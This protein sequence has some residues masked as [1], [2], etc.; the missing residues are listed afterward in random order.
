MSQRINFGKHTPLVEQPDFLAIQLESFKEFL[1]VEYSSGK[2]SQTQLYKIFQEYFPVTDSKKNVLIEFIDYTLEEPRYTPG[3]AIEKNITYSVPLKIH[4]RLTRK[5]EEKP[6]IINQT[7]FLGNI[8]YMTPQASFVIKGIERVIVAQI[9]RSYNAFFTH[10]KHISGTKLHSAKIIPARGAWIEFITDINNTIYVYINQKKKLPVTLLLR[11]MGY[12]TDRDILQL[13]NL[14]E[15]VKATKTELHKHI[16]KKL[17][18]KILKTWTQEF[19]DEET[20]EIISVERSEVVL[21]RNTEIDEK[22]IQTI[23]DAQVKNIVLR[24]KEANNTFYQLIHNTFRKDETN[25]EK[26]AIEHIY[27]QI[28]SSEP[29]DEETAREL[30]TQMLFSAQRS[31]LGKVGRYAINKKLGL[32]TPLDNY[33]ITQTDIIATLKHFLKFI[34]GQIPPDDID[35]LS[36]RRIR[37]VGEQLY[38]SFNTGIARMA[39]IIKERMNIRSSEEFKP[40]DLINPRTLTSVVD[41]FFATNPLSQ[42]MDQIN[43][44]SEI[45]HK[46]RI[47]SLG[48]GGVTREH[49]GFEIRDA[50]Y[51][52][53]GRACI[54]ETPEGLNIGL[55]LSLAGYAKINE[56]G[57]LQ[58]PYHKVKNGKVQRDQIHYLT[59]EEEEKKIIA[60]AQATLDKNSNFTQKKIN[61]RKQGEF[62]F[63]EGDKIDYQDVAS[64]QIVSVATSLIPFLEHNDAS[65]ALMGSNMQRQA[66]PLVKPQSP[67]VGTGIEEKVVK[68]FR[69]NI[70]AEMDGEVQYVD[71]NTI[72]IKYNQPKKIKNYSLEKDTKSYQLKK[73][74]KTNQGMAVSQ[75]PIVKKG[76]KI[77]KGDFLCEGY[78]TQN[79][80]LALGKNLLVA[81]MPWNGYVYEDGIVISSDLIQKGTFTSI[82]IHE[83]TLDLCETNQGPEEFTSEI[84][85]LSEEATQ[86]LD[87]NGIIR[88]GEKVKEGDILIG[89]IAP[90]N[91]TELSPESILLRAIF[92]ETAYNV[93]D[94]SLKAPP[95]FQGTVISSKI[96]SRAKRDKQARQEIKE[97]IEKLKDDINQQF[98]QLKQTAIEKLTKILN[99]QTLNAIS[100]IY[101]Q[102]VLPPGENPTTKTITQKIFI[103]P[104]KEPLLKEATSLKHLDLNNWTNDSSINEAIKILLTSYNTKH[105]QIVNEYKKEATNI[106]VGDELNVGVLKQAK[107]YIATKQTLKVGD[108]MAGR[109]GNKG[110]VAKIVAKEDM[111]YFEDGTPV[112]IVLNPLGVPARMNLGQLF[113]ALLGW[114]G[115]VLDKKYAVPVFDSPSLQ[116]IEKEM[117]KANLPHLGRTTLYDGQTGEA[118]EQKVTCGVIYMLKLNHLI[119]EKMHARSTGPYLL[120][121]GQPSG[122]RNQFG[123]QRLGEMEVWALEAYGAAHTLRESLTIKSDDIQGRSKTYEAIVKGKKIPTPDTPEAFKILVH[124]LHGLGIEV[125]MKEEITN[126]SENPIV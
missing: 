111:P 113:E 9:H 36:N 126:L 84:P 1:N 104:H 122:G 37:A 55:L 10:N 18:A 19:V 125:S 98:I 82:H 68:Y 59:A 60:Q 48:K 94:V 15:E 67:I 25:S 63:T 123:G 46:R 83:F 77:K 88:I 93:K 16:G 27:R 89:K 80:E 57:L 79:N 121:T 100:D 112:D 78:A 86:K 91:E 85:S 30:V 95:S 58:T 114:A 75:R 14:A 29:P 115:H 13:F 64:N 107:V 26:E 31:H 124:K 44:L 97:Q 87:E 4:L 33:A 71:A 99:K 61:V 51:S 17:A 47:S 102:V 53:Y 108:K 54:I 74:K 11:A 117:E 56:M 96:L 103:S 72:T 40:S 101:G 105:T 6:I 7:I 52:H 35:H 12:G 45:A 32:N 23:L 39:R 69:G 49:A 70:T 38:D 118:F 92:G 110:I 43:P 34:D 20:A 24:S 3:E 116:D 65:R 22:T 8:P 50:H 42:F 73:L 2:Q 90:K 119:D 81:F 76:Q 62:F 41:S 5:D 106:E 28:R 21:E 109:Y 66:V 120:I